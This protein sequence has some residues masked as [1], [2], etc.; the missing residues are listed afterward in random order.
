MF[1]SKA[2]NVA[3]CNWSCFICS[4]TT[5]VYTFILYVA[6]LNVILRLKKTII[7]KWSSFDLKNCCAVFKRLP[8][9][10]PFKVNTYVHTH[11]HTQHVPLIRLN[12]PIVSVLA[13]YSSTI[14]AIFK[15]HKCHCLH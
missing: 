4:F 3:V 13:G 12:N 11:I 6:H 2:D 1:A 15:L 8:K 5:Y 10:N 7:Y 9:I 14:L